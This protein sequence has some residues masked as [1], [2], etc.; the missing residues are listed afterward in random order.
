MRTILVV[1]LIPL[2]LSHAFPQGSESLSG[3]VKNSVTGTPIK[4]AMVTLYRMPDNEA[5]VD[6]AHFR[7]L[8]KTVMAGANGEFSFSGLTK[9]NYAVRPLKPGFVPDS[10]DSDDPANYIAGHARR[11]HHQ[12]IWA[13]GAQR[14]RRADAL[15]DR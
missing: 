1:V 8:V 3:T 14:F 9:G 6:A 7:P 2:A 4:G 11:R 5:D 15:S 12:S 10:T 13:S